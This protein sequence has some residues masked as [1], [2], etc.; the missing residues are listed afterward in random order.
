MAKLED[1]GEPNQGAGTQKRRKATI[2]PTHSEIELEAGKVSIVP[3]EPKFDAA[4]A[5]ASGPQIVKDFLKWYYSFS[6]E[7]TARYLHRL[8]Q[9]R[10]RLA[11]RRKQLD[12]N[13]LHFG[14]KHEPFTNAMMYKI[15]M[16]YIQPDIS[17]G[18]EYNQR[19]FEFFKLWMKMDNLPE[20]TKIGEAHNMTRLQEGGFMSMK[21]NNKLEA[22]EEE[23]ME[24]EKFTK[25]QR[26]TLELMQK[27]RFHNVVKNTHKEYG[28]MKRE[29]FNVMS[30][31]D[32]FGTLRVLFA[33][34]EYCANQLQK[35]G[36]W[37]ESEISLADD[38]RQRARLL[39]AAE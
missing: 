9:R 4:Y 28:I 1:W 5:A 17:K 31:C 25:Y 26:K 15:F 34:W 21:K 27:A 12:N 7:D 14:S 38:I 18:S 29:S 20:V 19:R 11:G 35:E 2:A 24:E 32:L 39:R 37:K 8:V 36:V 6:K 23:V 13:T 16:A 3:G 30:Q 33:D 10:F 22:I